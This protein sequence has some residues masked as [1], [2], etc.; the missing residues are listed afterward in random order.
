MFPGTTNDIDKIL[1]FSLDLSVIKRPMFN[2]EMGIN[3]V[4]AGGVSALCQKQRMMVCVNAPSLPVLMYPL[5]L[6]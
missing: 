6:C 3:W 2:T 5:P 1:S 4:S